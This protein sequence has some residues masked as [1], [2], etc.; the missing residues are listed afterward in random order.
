M[1]TIA[2]MTEQQTDLNKVLKQHLEMESFF[3][4]DFSVRGRP[5]SKE[6]PI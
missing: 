2:F 3:A 4:G 6:H 1:H 5:L